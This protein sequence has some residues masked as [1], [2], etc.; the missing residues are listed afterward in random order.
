M[1]F[2]PTTARVNPS[3]SCRA[4][5]LGLA[6]LALLVPGWH[7]SAVERPFPQHT[8]YC[9][10]SLRPAHVPASEL[11]Q[12]VRAFYAG[13]RAKYL[14]VAP[15]AKD[16]RF[17]DYNAEGRA[18]KGRDARSVSEGH[19][20]GM[21][22]TVLMADGATD[23]T[24]RDDFDA[25]YRFFRAHPSHLNP[26]LMGWLQA[27]PKLAN[28][29][30]GDSATDG[31]LDIAYAL[32]L[33]DRQ[34]G[35]RG[36]IDYAGEA[37]KVMAAILAHEVDPQRWTIQLGDWAHDDP[38]KSAAM[39]SSD[40][41]PQHWH[42]FAKA[43]GDP[44]WEKLRDQTYGILAQVFRANAPATG[45]IPDFIILREGR[46]QP[47][48]GKFLESKHDGAFGYNACRAPWRLALDYLL[49][50]DARA[51][52]QLQTLNEW[53]RGNAGGDPRKLTAGY[54]LDGR[55]LDR[56]DHAACFIAPLAVSAMLGQDQQWLDRLWES[57]LAREPDS[58]DDY[59]S[60]SV[61]LLCL[62][63]GSGNWWAP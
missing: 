59:F 45:L 3:S 20:Y 47:P 44:R 26:D 41:M 23:S 53:A 36:G 61:K 32:L 63:A 50:G 51:R 46:Y 56:E 55:P 31:D 14:R 9:S 7:A 52:P 25:L 27:G 34:W 17:V 2:A 21:L 19:G 38:A 28:A 12:A 24:A 29:E 13:W 4:V 10:L 42:T 60:N 39:R 30:G 37:R 48:K 8:P 22:A 62:I 49:N 6:F 54:T 33:A 16:Q 15:G 5:R 43:S 57:L 35:S 18:H 11:D 40:F 58:D 1:N